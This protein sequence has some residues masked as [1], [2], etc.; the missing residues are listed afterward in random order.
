MRE[1][2]KTEEMPP[3]W[4]KA[5]APMREKPMIRLKHIY[6]FLCSMLVLHHLLYVLFTLRGVFM[7]FLE[8]TY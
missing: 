1:M 6:N 5:M 2:S 3:V 4:E 7:R 8:L